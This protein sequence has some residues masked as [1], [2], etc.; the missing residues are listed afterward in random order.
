MST[1]FLKIL[2]RVIIIGVA[3]LVIL[4]LV[5]YG[6][7]HNNPTVVSS[8]K[9]DTPETLDLAKRACFDCHSNET[10]WP[11]YSNV[12][13]FSWLVYRDVVDGRRRLNFS[14]WQNKRLREPG[15]IASAVRE[16]KMPPLQYLIIHSSAK[17]TS[18]EKT[19]LSNGLL[20]TIG[21]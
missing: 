16:G 11:W 8:P 7:D 9:W 15:E 13:P 14:D 19:Q 17:L 12:A 20:K 3:L 5:P 2:P 4:Q 1:R 6:K 10:I 21:Q 18:A